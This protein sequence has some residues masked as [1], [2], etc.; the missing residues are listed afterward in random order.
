[1]FLFFFIYFKSPSYLYS[2]VDM[3]KSRRLVTP[4][5]ISEHM[6]HSYALAKEMFW[7]TDFRAFSPSSH[8]RT[9]STRRRHRG[10]RIRIIYTFI[11]STVPIR[12]RI[13]IKDLR[14]YWVLH[15]TW[16][17]WGIFWKIS[18]L[19]EKTDLYLS[20]LTCSTLCILS[21]FPL[22]AIWYLSSSIMFF[23]PL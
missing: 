1:M 12:R 4:Q 21:W 13:T 11:R 15:E 10:T 19:K 7:K 5:T 3:I 23:G 16:W 9:F 18:T 20:T 8:A 2:Q 14:V 17:Q 22:L 6:C